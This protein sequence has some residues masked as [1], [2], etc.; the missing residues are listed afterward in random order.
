MS[1]GTSFF[2]HNARARRSLGACSTHFLPPRPAS[3]PV[4]A[5]T[6]IYLLSVAGTKELLSTAKMSLIGVAFLPRWNRQWSSPK[7]RPAPGKSRYRMWIFP[8]PPL[9]VAPFSPGIVG[10]DFTPPFVSFRTTVRA[11]EA[12]PRG[13]ARRLWLSQTWKRRT[14]SFYVVELKSGG[15]ETR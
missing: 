10:F 3:T 13:L 15:R 9:W 5:D 1:M 4:S 8:T 12:S 2:R 6:R 7:L 14:L 11:F